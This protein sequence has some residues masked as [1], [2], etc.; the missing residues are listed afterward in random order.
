M[1]QYSIAVIQGIV[2]GLTEFLPISSTGH[3]ILSG[4]LLDFSGEKAKTFEIFIQL[5]SILAIVFL[6]FKKI[7]QIFRLKKGEQEPPCLNLVHI[8]LA[9]A[10]A[11]VLGLI[12]HKT[13]KT[14]LFSPQTVLVGL[15]VGGAFLIFAEKKA[16]P[17]SAV[18][19]DEITYKQS[20]LIGCFQCLALW[21][22]FSRSG[23][24]IAGGILCGANHKTAADFS[25][26]V[27]VPMMFAASGLDL[28]KSYKFLEATDLG[29]FATGFVVSFFVA[30]LVV[31]WFLKFLEQVKLTPFAYYRFV[32]A[33][34]YFW[35]VLK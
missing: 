15:V 8:G 3:L 2:Q 18:T 30:L 1:D 11:V 13:I 4:T 35:F 27:A 17:A 33:F 23:A 12:F 9:M 28:F 20:F 5:G 29:F 7:L 10:P 24:T 14:Y 26:L 34:L 16:P 32:A 31:A 6:Y 25:F 19:L 21:P 22:G